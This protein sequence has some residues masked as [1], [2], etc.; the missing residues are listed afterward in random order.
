[1]RRL[2]LVALFAVAALPAFARGPECRWSKTW[3][4]ALAE[5]KARNVPIHVTFHK[6]G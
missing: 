1:M 2:A 3:D 5:A 6:D 4:E